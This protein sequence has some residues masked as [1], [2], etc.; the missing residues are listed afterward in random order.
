MQLT[1]ENSGLRRLWRFCVV[2]L[3]YN[4]EKVTVVVLALSIIYGHRFPNMIMGFWTVT[5]LS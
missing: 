1:S 2:G 5:L 4:L 3:F